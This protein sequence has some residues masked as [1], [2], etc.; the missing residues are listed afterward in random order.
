MPLADSP[1][2]F[3]VGAV[4]PGQVYINHV[5]GLLEITN[6]LPAGRQARSQ[7]WEITFIAL[8]AYFEAFCKDQFA[9]L[10]NIRPELLRNFR[11]DGRDTMVDAADLIEQGALAS[12]RVGSLLAERLPMG[13]AH[14]INGAYSALLNLAPFSKKQA[15]EFDR[16]L[17]VRNQLVHHGG[18]ITSKFARQHDEAVPPENR[19]FYSLVLS[20]AFFGEA[21][22]FFMEVAGTIV[23]QSGAKLRK[24]IEE[25]NLEC[26]PD[27]LSAIEYL[28]EPFKQAA[29]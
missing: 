23:R 17:R 6:H 8:V 2:R 28:I 29:V 18:V 11:A 7:E 20:A 10:V 19:Y 4:A 9:A 16:L 5:I 3:F 21:Y 26:S 25:N 15:K 12:C 14:E 13:T 24:F 27:Q 22:N 1:L